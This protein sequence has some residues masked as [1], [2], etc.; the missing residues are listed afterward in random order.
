MDSATFRLVFAF[1][2]VAVIYAEVTNVASQPRV[3]RETYFSRPFAMPRKRSSFI[4]DGQEKRASYLG[5]PRLG[6][7]YLALPRMG[8]SGSDAS[9][10]GGACCTT[11]LK[12][13]W[14]IGEEG[15][16]AAR[17]V[18]HAEACCAGYVEVEGAKPDGTF[19]TMCVP[20][21]GP[22]ANTNME[23]GSD[24]VM[25]KLKRLYRQ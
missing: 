2:F 24:D 8:R 6:R 19:Y 14:V 18:C 9:T 17:D 12:K 25:E 1:V 4:E 13:D 23:A 7:G 20:R 21:C 10:N 22:V 5:F 16:M 3:R 15:K 11:G